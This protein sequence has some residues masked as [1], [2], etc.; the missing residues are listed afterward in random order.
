[1][2]A[3]RPRNRLLRQLAKSAPD[4]YARVF[5]TLEPVPLHRR[6]RLGAAHERAE[7]VYFL[8]SG[9]VSLVGAT[10]SGHSV[11]TCKDKNHTTVPLA[12]CHAA[13]AYSSSFKFTTDR[14]I[15][16]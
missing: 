15:I 4:V 14:V 5:D 16:K 9:V 6:A 10:S 13:M 12:I 7:W 3:E 1:M 8:E 11:D 2:P